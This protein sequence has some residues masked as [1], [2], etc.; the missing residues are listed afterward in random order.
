VPWSNFAYAFPRAAFV[1]ES[2]DSGISRGI[3]VLLDE[4]I[5]ASHGGDSTWKCVKLAKIG[6]RM[7]HG[8]FWE[9]EIGILL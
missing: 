6:P 2:P 1:R 7:S 3:H 8:Q 4:S 9:I 5:G